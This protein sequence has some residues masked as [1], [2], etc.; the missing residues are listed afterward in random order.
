MPKGW[1]RVSLEANTRPI[2]VERDITSAD[3]VV[4]RGGSLAALV[5]ACIACG[6]GLALLFVFWPLMLVALL[7]VG[8]GRWILPAVLVSGLL[9][10]G[11]LYVWELRVRRDIADELRG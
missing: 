6:L 5:L 2:R 11:V 7:D 4:P 9:L 1:D 3:L 8:V 10:A